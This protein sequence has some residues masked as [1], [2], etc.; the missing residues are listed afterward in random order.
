MRSFGFLILIALITFAIS[1]SRERQCTTKDG[2]ETC[3][4]WNPNTCCHGYKPGQMCGAAFRRCCET[5]DLIKN[6]MNIDPLKIKLFPKT[7]NK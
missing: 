5:H 1:I 4:W 6:W 3:C 7:K 2:K